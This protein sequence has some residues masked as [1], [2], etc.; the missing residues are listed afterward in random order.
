MS[1]V[2]QSGGKRHHK[3]KH[4][5][6]DNWYPPPSVWYIIE[7]KL[8]LSHQ[9]RVPRWFILKCFQTPVQAWKHLKTVQTLK[10][11]DFV[12]MC[13]SLLSPVLIVV[14]PQCS[15]RSRRDHYYRPR[16]PLITPRG[17][18]RL[19]FGPTLGPG[20]PGL[21][22]PPRPHPP[23]PPRDGGPYPPSS[24]GDGRPMGSWIILVCRMPYYLFYFKGVMSWEI[25]FS[26]SFWYMKG[27]RKMR[28]LRIG[29]LVTSESS[30][31][32]LQQKTNA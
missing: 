24:L 2:H 32:P 14:L 4:L 16:P 9:L 30:E 8:S 25:K 27:N 18:P 19:T 23:L 21:G 20:P 5:A 3:P 28:D 13:G 7:K 10:E 1:Q 26:L 6:L 17:A 22:G 31:T 29:L 12:A 15:Q 11:A